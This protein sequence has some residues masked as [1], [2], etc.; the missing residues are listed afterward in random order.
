[1]IQETR[2]EWLIE[3]NARKAQFHIGLA[4]DQGGSQD[5]EWRTI[6]IVSGSYNDAHAWSRQWLDANPDAKVARD[7]RGLE[8]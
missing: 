7:N 8:E 1:M 3:W 4:I 2:D 5:G 6:G